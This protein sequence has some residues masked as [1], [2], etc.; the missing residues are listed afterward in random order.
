MGCFLA[1]AGA[2]V[3]TTVIRK[4][5][6]K[7]ETALDDSQRQSPGAGQT[8]NWSQRL[9][10][11]NIMLWT[12][13]ALLCLEHIWRGE[14]VFRPPFFTALNASGGGTAML[15]E[16]A[17]EG[18]AITAGIIIVWAITVGVVSLVQR[19]TKTAGICATEDSTLIDRV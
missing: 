10:W 14:V 15:R 1:P 18:V 13:T 5:V 11:L 2:A 12:S 16:I 8:I 17:T 19:R 9:H 3:A 4:M 6:K 7:K